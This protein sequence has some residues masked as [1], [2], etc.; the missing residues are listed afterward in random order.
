MGHE[1]VAD[2]RGRVTLSSELRKRHGDRFIAISMPDGI[3]LYPV[4]KGPLRLKGKPLAE[5]EAKRIAMEEFEREIEDEYRTI[6]G[7]KL[8]RKR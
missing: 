6:H 3:H 1:L 2:E 5:G 8:P 4:P 7:G